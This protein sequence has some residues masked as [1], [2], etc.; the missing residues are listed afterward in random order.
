MILQDSILKVKINVEEISNKYTIYSLLT[1]KR[2]SLG[3]G[4][5][6]KWINLGPAF[7]FIREVLGLGLRVRRCSPPV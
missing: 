2:I 3:D 1:T 4:P 5:S 6:K 7:E